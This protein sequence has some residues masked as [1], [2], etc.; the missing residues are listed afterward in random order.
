[1][2]DGGQEKEKG[3]D[4]GGKGIKKE[5]RNSGEEWEDFEAQQEDKGHKK[6]ERK[7]G[8]RGKG[9]KREMEW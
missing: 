1:V 6:I 4:R 5:K 2:E 8:I 7:G 3:K 9:E